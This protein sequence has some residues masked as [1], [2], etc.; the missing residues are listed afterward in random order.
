MGSG[1]TADEPLS[2]DEAE[3]QKRWCS[4]N[5]AILIVRLSPKMRPFST[6]TFPS[7][8]LLIQIVIINAALC[9]EACP[10]RSQLVQT[11]RKV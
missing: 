4:V 6:D 10:N 7:H 3:N 9:H 8:A 1:A 5:P 2:S 11:A